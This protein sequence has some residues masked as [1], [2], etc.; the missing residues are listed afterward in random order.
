MT[1]MENREQATGRGPD[2]AHP[3][4]SGMRAGSQAVQFHPE[5]A[6]RGAAGS[7]SPPLAR[8]LGFPAVLLNQVVAV[9][10]GSCACPVGIHR[11][12]GS[13]VGTILLTPAQAQVWARAG[14][15]TLVSAEG[16]EYRLTVL[17]PQEGASIALGTHWPPR[18][19][20]GKVRR[21]AAAAAHDVGD[22]LTFPAWLARTAHTSGE[23]NQQL[24]RLVDRIHGS[25]P[26]TVVHYGQTFGHEHARPGQFHPYDHRGLVGH[27]GWPHEL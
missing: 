2:P 18:E 21:V 7:G 27:E 14:R 22:L 23:R 1:S 3:H 15:L 17:A 10:V 12:T 16:D 5:H 13:E 8:A 6:A 25:S 20:A 11:W 4:A 26:R 24:I 9:E 19:P